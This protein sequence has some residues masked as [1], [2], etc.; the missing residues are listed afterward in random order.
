VPAPSGFGYFRYLLAYSR[1]AR[2]RVLDAASALTP[3][4]YLA[5]RGLDHGSIHNTLMHILAAEVLWRRRWMG[6]GDA[7]I[8]GPGIAQSFEGLRFLWN[9]EDQKL[10]AFLDSLAPSTLAASVV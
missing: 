5:P 2:D 3:T 10:D 6:E 4:E 1:W 7:A 8:G 9:L